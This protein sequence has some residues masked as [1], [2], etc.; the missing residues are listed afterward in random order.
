MDQ[1][2]ST[3]DVQRHLESTFLNPKPDIEGREGPLN[4]KAKALNPR[5]RTLSPS[6]DQYSNAQSPKAFKTL[7]AAKPFNRTS[8]KRQGFR[9]QGVGLRGYVLGLS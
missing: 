3:F 6:L 7:T 1:D 5:P 8:S 4:P 9:V 2:V